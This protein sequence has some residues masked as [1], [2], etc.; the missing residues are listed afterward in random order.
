MKNRDFTAREDLAIK[1]NS[2]AHSVLRSATETRTEHFINSLQIP[3]ICP[4]PNSQWKKQHFG[5]TKKWM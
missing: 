4:R 3:I 1:N 5:E 2:T